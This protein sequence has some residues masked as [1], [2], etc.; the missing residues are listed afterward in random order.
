M[1]N[2]T[3]FTLALVLTC[4]PAYSM[5]ADFMTQYNAAIEATQT[6]P[7][8][9][10]LLRIKKK[11]DKCSNNKKKDELAPEYKKAWENYQLVMNK[12]DLPGQI[13]HEQVRAI[14]EKQNNIEEKMKAASREVERQAKWLPTTLLDAN[15]ERA[16][17]RTLT[18]KKTTL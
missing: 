2:S 18:N 5:D 4:A 14:K 17:A 7:T 8:Y 9:K 10:K 13:P 1:K 3:L 12:A 11:M 16:A 15:R 6:D